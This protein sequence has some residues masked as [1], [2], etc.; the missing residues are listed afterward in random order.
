LDR[1]W[2]RFE[3]CATL[4]SYSDAEEIIGMQPLLEHLRHYA[5]AYIIVA[6]CLLPILY[7]TRRWSVPAILYTIEIAIYMG[8]MHL[9]V[10]MLVGF[11]AWFKDQSSMK[12]AF[13]TKSF[14]KPD[15][16]TPL[17]QFWDRAAYKPA[18]LVYVELVFV[19]LIL[20]AVWRYRPM[21]I[22]RQRKH[23]VNSPGKKNFAGYNP[24][25]YA[26]PAPKGGKK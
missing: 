16:G 13:D 11:T 21:R 2:Q 17:L 20:Y 25:R 22:Q 10:W 12:R 14:V 6:V 15:W 18:W 9:A 7:L 3:A 8:L 4:N 19:V 23:P 26:S 5:A 1:S 24:R